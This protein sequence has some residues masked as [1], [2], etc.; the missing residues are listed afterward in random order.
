MNKADTHYN[1]WTN[2]QTWNTSLTFQEHFA[3]LAGE[4][5][6]DT[7][8]HMAECFQSM[9]EELQFDDLKEETLA[10]TYMAQYLA[11]VNWVEI[12]ESYFDEAKVRA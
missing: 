4:Q 3:H 2:V 1:G 12:A 11:K 9:V 5:K 10:H 6:Y 7:V 8:A